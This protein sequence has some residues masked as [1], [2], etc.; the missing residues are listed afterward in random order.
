MISIAYKCL[1][2]IEFNTFPKFRSRILKISKF[3][4]TFFSKFLQTLAFFLGSFIIQR[5]CGAY[6]DQDSREIVAEEFMF[7]D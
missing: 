1:I 7:I 5:Y 4:L 3:S 6:L 2:I